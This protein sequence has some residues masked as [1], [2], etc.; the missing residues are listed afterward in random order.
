MSPIQP[1]TKNYVAKK[2]KYIF[3]V[4]KAVDNII[5]QSIHQESSEYPTCD[6]NHTIKQSN[7]VN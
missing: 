5:V 6:F 3:N 2:L 7:V 4:T 1:S